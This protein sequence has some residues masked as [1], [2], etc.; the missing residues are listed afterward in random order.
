MWTAGNDWII[1]VKMWQQKG[2]WVV[3]NSHNV[4]T[5][6]N[7]EWTMVKWYPI[8]KRKTNEWTKDDCN[9]IKKSGQHLRKMTYELNWKWIRG[10]W[11][12]V[13]V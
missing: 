5:K 1:D 8:K 6:A 2:H 10:Q 9:C 13:T 11:M 12:T 3:Q 7:D 4:W